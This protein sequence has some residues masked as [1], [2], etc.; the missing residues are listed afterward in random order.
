MSEHK[1][2]RNQFYLRRVVLIR[3]TKNTLN[4]K[5]HIQDCSVLNLI[6]NSHKVYTV[7][8]FNSLTHIRTILYARTISKFGY[9]LK[10][11]T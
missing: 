7:R 3:Y 1:I 8:N 4:N 9:L 2:S 10:N 5:L 6:N 11:Q